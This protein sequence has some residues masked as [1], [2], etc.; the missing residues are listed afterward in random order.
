MLDLT[1]VLVLNDPPPRAA[2]APSERE[3]GGAHAERGR[4]V[5]ENKHS[6]DGESTNRDRASV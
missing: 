4:G 2:G 3:G 5:I 6:T 1:R